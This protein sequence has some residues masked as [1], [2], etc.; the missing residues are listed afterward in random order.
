MIGCRSSAS[1]SE[2]LLRH[3]R[4]Q[5][6][7]DLQPLA[8]LRMHHPGQFPRHE[9]SEQPPDTIIRTMQARKTFQNILDDFIRCLDGFRAGD[10]LCSHPGFQSAYHSE[11]VRRPQPV[12]QRSSCINQ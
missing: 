2:R 3:A 4:Q 7:G 8:E 1:A 9:Q 12:G 11:T 6:R 10:R 5:V